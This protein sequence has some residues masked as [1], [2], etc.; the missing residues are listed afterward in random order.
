MVEV[1]LDSAFPMCFPLC[2]EVPLPTLICYL[3]NALLRMISPVSS[4]ASSRPACFP[5]CDCEAT[6]M[7]Y[8]ASVY[9]ENY[10]W[11]FVKTSRSVL[12]GQPEHQPHFASRRRKGCALFRDPAACFCSAGLSLRLAF[13]AFN[14]RCLPGTSLS[15]PGLLLRDYSHETVSGAVNP[16]C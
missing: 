6:M 4:R 13:T 11:T 2:C 16:A 15:C 8:V 3:P 14:F 7:R 1:N 5:H 10:A 12:G 9:Q